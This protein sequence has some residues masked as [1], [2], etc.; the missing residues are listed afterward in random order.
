MAPTSAK[1]S[2]PSL[3]CSVVC[4]LG[5]TQPLASWIQ[6]IIDVRSPQNDHGARLNASA[7]P[8][9]DNDLTAALAQR[10]W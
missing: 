9:L 3:Q 4:R 10:G 6:V 2:L 7:T 5:R 1:A 8:K